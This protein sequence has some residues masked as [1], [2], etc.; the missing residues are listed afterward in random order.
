M[1]Y[2]EFLHRYADSAS[3][4]AIYDDD[5]SYRE[6][7]V[8]IQVDSGVMT[9]NKPELSFAM[10]YDIDNWCNDCIKNELTVTLNPITER[11]NTTLLGY[12]PHDYSLVRQNK[13][14]QFSSVGGDVPIPDGA[15]TLS[16]DGSS[17]TVG[18]SLLVD[19]FA[20]IPVEK[21]WY[22]E[23]NGVYKQKGQEVQKIFFTT[24][25]GVAVSEIPRTVTETPQMYVS[26][27]EYR[28]VYSGGAFEINQLKGTMMK[29]NN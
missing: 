29:P 22:E 26:E 13:Y 27:S 10:L 14:D 2:T 16:A 4:D 1:G 15:V 8:A 12:R 7:W 21:T 18:E 11:Y 9:Y 19:G 20:I 3:H 5:S 28:I 23:S 17:L 6:P 24:L 25:N